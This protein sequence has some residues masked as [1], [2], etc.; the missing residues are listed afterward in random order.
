M[1]R[2]NHQ[3]PLLRDVE[4]FLRTTRVTETRL[5]RVVLGDPNFVR[6]LRAGRAVRAS[7]A[8]KVRSYILSETP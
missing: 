7:T 1:A 3:A 2:S 4:A 5:G 8:A 6:E